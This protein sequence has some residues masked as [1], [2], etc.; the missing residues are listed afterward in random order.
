MKRLEICL[1]K[2]FYTPGEEVK[3][4]A[5]LNTNKTMKISKI[6]LEILGL[7]MTSFTVHDWGRM[8]WEEDDST[9]QSSNY[10]I[11][12]RERLAKQNELLPSEHK[13]PISFQIP[14]DA[15]A[16]YSG[17]NINIKYI[18]NV[19]AIVPFWFDLKTE[20]EFWVLYNRKAIQKMT[21]PL[22]FASENFQPQSMSSPTASSLMGDSKSKSSF[23]VEL[24]KDAYLAGEEITGKI[25]INNPSHKKF[26]KIDV[27]LKAEEYA[28]AK[29]NKEY[30]VVEKHK[31]RI[32]EG[33]IVDSV[34]S[35]FSIPI[36]RDAI[37]S[38]E[39][40]FS[41]LNWYLQFNLD[42]GLTSDEKAQQKIYIYQWR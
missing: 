23:L 20:R 42:I 15:P 10:I 24:E 29:E 31:S 4:T 14:S 19:Q 11:N 28:Y 35:K 1:D 13:Y 3:G 32:D 37:T 21:K 38:F 27:L 18:I 33:D 40:A 5:I 30:K 12:I 16:S 8:E 22:S 26:R 6:A 2:D 7:E 9:K 39:G 34:P 41:S 17:K 36:P 25:T